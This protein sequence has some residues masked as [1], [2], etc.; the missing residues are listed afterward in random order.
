MSFYVNM[1]GFTGSWT[2]FDSM[3][4]VV[5]TRPILSFMTG[6]FAE[7]QL[8]Q[9]EDGSVLFHISKVYDNGS[10][11]AVPST[12]ITGWDGAPSTYGTMFGV[13]VSFPA[14]PIA[15]AVSLYAEI[16][17]VLNRF[18]VMINGGKINGVSPDC[19]EP[20]SSG[21]LKE[22]ARELKERGSEG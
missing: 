13:E 19:L 2:G 1:D 18:E 12:E 9:G 7:Y 20:R 11:T 10:H 5:R 15:F 6:K 14:V 8:L 21:I 17:D 3:A 16:A 4:G 22:K